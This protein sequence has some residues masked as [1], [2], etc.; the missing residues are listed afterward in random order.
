M[1][2]GVVKM[3]PTKII[4]LIKRRL[5]YGS[6]IAELGV[7]AI[8]FDKYLSEE[9]NMKY[10]ALYKKINGVPAPAAKK[11][12]SIDQKVFEKLFFVQTPTHE[13]A[14]FFMCSK[15]ALRGWVEET[16]GCTLEEVR[17]KNLV[18]GKVNLR[19]NQFNLAI[20]NSAMAIWLGR[21]YLSQSENGLTDNEDD[22]KDNYSPAFMVDNSI[23]Q[24]FSWACKPNPFYCN[25]T[26]S[27]LYGGRDGGKS[28]QVADMVIVAAMNRKEKGVIL[29]GRE[30]Q[31]SLEKS[32]YPLIISRIEYFKLNKFFKVLKNKIVCIH[33]SVEIIF[34]G[35]REGSRSDALKGLH[36]VF[37]FWGEEAQSFS[38]KT[39]DILI[40]TII[41]FKDCRLIFTMNR[42]YDNDP[43]F[44]EFSEKR[45]DET[46]L[47]NI[48]YYDNK[49]LPDAV[50][51]DAELLKARDL[52]KYMHIYGGE[53]ARYYENSLWTES[54]INA[55]RLN[56]VY[57]RDNYEELIVACDPAETKKEYSNE[58]G[59]VVLGKLKGKEEVHIIHDE[60]SQ[61]SPNEF[62]SDVCRLYELYDADS[63]IV[64]TNA[65]GDF[66]K[67]AILEVNNRI[68]VIEVRAGV[69][70]VKRAIPCAN[71]MQMGKI[72]HYS[73]LSTLESQ[74]MK[75]TTSGYQG[76]PGESPD[77]VDAM[78]WGIFH[79]FG[80]NDKDTVD[81]VFNSDMFPLPEER[82]IEILYKIFYCHFV[83]NKFVLFDLS[84]YSDGDRTNKIL[85]NHVYVS[86]INEAY[87]LCFRLLKENHGRSLCIHDTNDGF[88]LKDKLRH[89]FSNLSLYD[90]EEYE[91]MT[92]DEKVNR[93]YNDILNGLVSSLDRE[94]FI[95]EVTK[96]K[97]NEDFKNPILELLC[98]IVLCSK[99]L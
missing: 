12:M 79:L 48:N 10:R 40:P 7:T 65:G 95:Q 1:P 29:C 51:S 90:I 34:M 3:C 5:D 99:H 98:D 45:K 69:D 66:I 24:F 75:V 72:K 94:T 96:Y 25:K 20:E 82:N 46:L 19:E 11:V 23:N 31:N 52:N 26:Y 49:F 91:K 30:I 93:I 6:I 83:H 81:L 68:N 43:V 73:G 2:K 58:Y 84:I 14:D 8:A 32:S 57:E 97:V 50:K 71:L 61:K 33:N 60:S 87:D 55:S 15:K 64:E 38:Q 59:V 36:E 42:Q 47:L 77:R 54:V 4:E 35:M 74:M 62:A 53:P 80:I 76:Q 88:I 13:I 92:I 70:K 44:V 89:H 86:Y 63:V 21:Q 56:V 17:A 67:S 27:L 39:I 41:R 85:V 16:Y 28:V 37:F 18:K 78:V 22:S 9:F